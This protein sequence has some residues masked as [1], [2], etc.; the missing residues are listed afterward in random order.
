MTCLLT[1]YFV[2]YL[3]ASDLN[4]QPGQEWQSKSEILLKI[5]RIRLEIGWNTQITII[6]QVKNRFY[7]DLTPG[8][9]QHGRLLVTSY[10]PLSPRSQLSYCSSWCGSDNLLPVVHRFSWRVL[11]LLQHIELIISVL[12]CIRLR[13]VIK[14]VFPKVAPLN[15][16]SG[17]GRS[18]TVVQLQ[19]EEGPSI[20]R[21]SVEERVSPPSEGS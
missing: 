13:P 16:K 20:L 3:I 6:I 4:M 2:Y 7:S 14:T 11:H 17:R 15:S 21:I 19:S 12:I 9:S 1:E 18:P 8:Q 5:K 10:R